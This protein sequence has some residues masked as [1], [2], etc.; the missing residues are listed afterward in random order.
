MTLSQDEK[1]NKLINEVGLL[2]LDLKA[3]MQHLEV[4]VDRYFRVTDIHAVMDKFE[5]QKW[6]PST[7]QERIK[8]YLGFMQFSNGMIDKKSVPAYLDSF[9]TNSTYNRELKM[10]KF[11]GDTLELG[12]W[13]KALKFKQ[14]KTVLK[15]T[16]LPVQYELNQL[17]NALS[18]DSQT[19]FMFLHSTGL[20][21]NEVLSL[22]WSDFDFDFNCI[23]ARRLHTGITKH[24]WITFFTE[25]SKLFLNM[26]NP[27]PF[28][29]SLEKFRYEFE[30]VQKRLEITMS[31]KDFRLNFAEKCHE[32]GLSDDIIN[33]FQGRIP[34]SVIGKHYTSYSKEKLAIEYQKVSGLLWLTNDVRHENQ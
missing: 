5:L 13:I 25:E 19:L 6:S 8:S 22:K 3:V 30:Q 14:D 32:A 26:D 7:K 28:M 15:T 1:I 4:R 21:V 12:A 16:R 31:I 9:T 34:Q 23:D 33:A 2:K 27:D 29:I 11:L 24:S 17:L 20:R 18:D 10:M